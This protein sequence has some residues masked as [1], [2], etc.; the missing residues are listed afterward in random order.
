MFFQVKNDFCQVS[1]FFVAFWRVTTRQLKVTCG[2]GKA[3]G[4]S[5]CAVINERSFALPSMQG[6][7]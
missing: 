4:N 7:W 3:Y 5:Q 6:H 2:Y 1:S